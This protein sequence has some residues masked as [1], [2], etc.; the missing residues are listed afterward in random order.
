MTT[1]G[2][3]ACGDAS[4]ASSHKFSSGSHAEGRFTGKEAVRYCVENKAMPNVDAAALDALKKKILA[5][6]N[7]YEQFSA[8]ST[9]P[10]YQS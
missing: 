2:L 5:P 8:L 7:T 9:D 1:K 10:G 4:G 6:L 3:F